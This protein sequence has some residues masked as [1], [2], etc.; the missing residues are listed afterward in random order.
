MPTPRPRPRYRCCFCGVTFSAC[1]GLQ[2]SGADGA[3]LLGHIRQSHPRELKPF[4]DQ[5]HTDD[6]ITPA[7]LQA[8]EAEGTHG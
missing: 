3:L 5:V 4:L 7:I 6:D 2:L 1:P 8:Y